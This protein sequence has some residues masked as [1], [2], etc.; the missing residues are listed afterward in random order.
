MEIIVQ[1]MHF[2]QEELSPKNGIVNMK[3]YSGGFFDPHY[4]I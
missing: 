2:F 1:Y 3:H 4:W